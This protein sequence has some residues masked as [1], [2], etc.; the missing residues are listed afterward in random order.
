MKDEKEFQ[1]IRD[2]EDYTETINHITEVQIGRIN[3]DNTIIDKASKR[4]NEKV[5]RDKFLM[6]NGLEIF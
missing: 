1:E 2:T 4:W 6:V 5:H 3:I